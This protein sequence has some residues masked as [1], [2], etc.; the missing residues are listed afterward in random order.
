VAYYLTQPDAENNI[1]IVNP[2]NFQ[3]ISALTSFPTDFNTD[4]PAIQTIFVKVFDLGGN[5]CSSVFSTFKVVIYPEPNIPLNI[6]NYSDC[7]NMT[8]SDADDANGINGNI[9]LKNKIPEILANYDPAKFADF[10]VRFYASLTAAE[11]GD[12]T[13]ALNE[14]TFENSINGQEIFVRVENIKNTPIIC[15]NTRLSFNININPLPDF[16]VMGEENIEDPLIVCL[17]DTPLVLEV[18]NPLATYTYQWTNQA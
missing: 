15:V 3:N 11:I 4:E 9:A 5:K 14:N 7:D 8:D 17:N 13:N 2:T 12:P 18:E 1:E 6:S 16:T 10:A